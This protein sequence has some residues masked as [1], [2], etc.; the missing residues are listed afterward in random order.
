MAEVELLTKNDWR[1]GLKPLVEIAIMSGNRKTPAGV[2]TNEQ[3]PAK[4][5]LRRFD[6]DRR[7][8]MQ[9]SPKVRLRSPVRD[10]NAAKSTPST[11]GI[12]RHDSPVSMT[13]PPPGSSIRRLIALR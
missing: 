2:R 3:P 13:D 4:R 1:S 6:S 12:Y 8:W 7:L 5:S 9:V 11:S 10:D